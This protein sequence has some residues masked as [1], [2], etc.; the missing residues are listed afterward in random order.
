MNITQKN[1]AKK[2]SPGGYSQKRGG[3]KMKR[4]SIFMTTFFLLIILSSGNVFCA[5]SSETKK[6]KVNFVMASTATEEHTY[7]K[8][9]RE[10]IEE[11]KTRTDG[12]IT[13]EMA[14]A[15]ALGGEREL[16]EAIQMGALEMFW[17]SDLGHGT[18]VKDINFS[19]LPY[20]FP[21]Y[22]DVDQHY[23]NG[24]VG[25]EVVRILEEND[26]KVIA[27]LENDY[28]GLTNSER[29]IKSV[30]DLKGLT[31]RVPE[32]PQILDFFEM[33]G[34]TTASIPI[35]EVLTAL[36][37]GTV[38]GQDNGVILTYTFGF[39]EA[40]KYFTSTKHVYSG[41]LISVNPDWWNSL[42][43]DDQELISEL[44]QKYGKKQIERNRSLVS[45]YK[46]KMEESGIQVIDVTPKMD[47]EMREI[48]VKLWEKYKDRYDPRIMKRLIKEFG[49]TN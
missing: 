27:W 8:A 31:L 28:R 37:T 12:R 47:K 2:N 29:P 10:M 24:W 3:S 26:I 45:T 1:F 41:G 38:D 34:A 32:I 49:T 42:H 17:G 19:T 40:Q 25:E 23:I 9:A 18:V 14:W 48:A 30:D 7:T 5:D 4:L 16:T 22:E 13:V 35:T 43:P 44:A 11:L 36:Q 15:G 46:K 33:M 21:T 39:H 20:L 6:K